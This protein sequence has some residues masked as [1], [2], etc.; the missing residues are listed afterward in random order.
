MKHFLF[1]L[2]ISVFSHSAFAEQPL[3]KALTEQYFS[4]INYVEKIQKKY[5]ELAQAMN[6]LSF[7]DKDKF[8]ST[9][10]TFS[11]YTEID[12]AIKTTGLSGGVEQLY[13]LSVRIMGGV[14]SAQMEKMPEGTNVDSLLAMKQKAVTEMKNANMPK[15]MQEKLLKTLKEQEA[16]L[17][18]MAEL[19]K[20]ASTEDK[21]FVKDNLSW[22]MQNLPKGE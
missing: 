21:A 22:I 14:M 20:K 7:N 18:N 1:V 11:S 6:G 2:F 17:V 13:D 19:S 9:V 3:T 16:N 15:A 10:K 4:A 5:P 12:S 8:L